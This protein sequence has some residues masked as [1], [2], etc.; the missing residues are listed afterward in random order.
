[1]AE[2]RSQRKQQTAPPLSSCFVCAGCV[3][4]KSELPSLQ[5]RQQTVSA[6]SHNYCALPTKLHMW[7]KGYCFTLTCK[8]SPKGERVHWLMQQ[9]SKDAISA[10]CRNGAVQKYLRKSESLWIYYK[11]RAKLDWTT[12]TLYLSKRTSNS[13]QNY[14][15]IEKKT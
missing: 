13:S 5:N 15:Y 4:A 2:N 7:K 3:T 6:L 9:L 11:F 8:G 10:K 12:L 14:K 1:M